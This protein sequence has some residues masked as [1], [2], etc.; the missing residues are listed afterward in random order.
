MNILKVLYYIQKVYILTC[1]LYKVFMKGFHNLST[2]V[3]F[4]KNVRG[5]SDF[6]IANKLFVSF[7]DNLMKYASLSNCGTLSMI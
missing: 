3:K 4:T 5:P 1:K 6:I 2:Y 7:Q